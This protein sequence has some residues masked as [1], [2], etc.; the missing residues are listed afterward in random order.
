MISP[1]IVRDAKPADL[2]ALTSLAKAWV[3][4][5]STIGQTG[6]DFAPYFDKGFLAVAEHHDIMIGFIAAQVIDQNLAIFESPGPYIQIDELYV[7]SDARRSGIGS[8]LLNYLKS[9]AK[10]RG[11]RRFHVFSASRNLDDVVRFYGRHGFKVWGIQ[12][13]AADDET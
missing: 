12:A 10:D 1:V 5:G 13:Y 9:T 7:V 2:N 3:S 11:V 6:I 4:E 8:L